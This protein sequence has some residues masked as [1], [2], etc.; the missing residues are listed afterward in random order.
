MFMNERFLMVKPTFWFT[1]FFHLIIQWAS[2]IYHKDIFERLDE[3][4]NFFLL[5]QILPFFLLLVIRWTFRAS[6]LKLWDKVQV[7]VKQK[8]YLEKKFQLLV[9]PFFGICITILGIYL[10]YVPLTQT[11]LYKN[12]SNVDP[13][14][15]II[16]RENSMKLLSQQWLK[17]LFVFFDKFLGGVT[18]SMLTL[19]ILFKAS[20]KKYLTILIYILMICIIVIGAMLPGARVSGALIFF[21][22]FATVAFYNIKKIKIFKYLLL[23]MLIIMPAVVTQM[24]KYNK[25]GPE[26]FWFAFEEILIR[27]ALFIPMEVGIYWLDYVEDYGYWG[28]A[29]IPKIAAIVGVESVNVPNYL[30]NHYWGGNLVTSGFM[31][32]SF[33]FG[34]FSYF[35]YWSFPI[36]LAAILILDFWVIAY[37]MVSKPLLIPTIVTLNGACI[38]LISSDYLTLYLTYG[39]FTGI[40]FMLGLSNFY[41]KSKII[42]P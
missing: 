29:G 41:K 8:E 21:L 13:L 1:A 12:F 33:V 19:L 36:L 39:F 4:Y 40:I 17:Y 22:C 24:F 5:T 37:R 7:T 42:K 2:A 20:K 15:A 26:E 9:I 34:Y 32:G 23:S 31:N 28:I 16:A 35:G 25:I 11:G 30:A 10:M 27:R 6:A 18:A 38:N 14:E 3:P